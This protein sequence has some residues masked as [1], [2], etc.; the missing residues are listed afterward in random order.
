[1]VWIPSAIERIR[2]R[3]GLYLKGEYKD[4]ASNEVKMRPDLVMLKEYGRS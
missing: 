1:M 3:T 2:K 4:R